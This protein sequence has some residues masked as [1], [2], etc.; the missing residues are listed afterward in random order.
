MFRALL[1]T[2]FILP[3]M[4]IGVGAK[5]QSGL[6]RLARTDRELYYSNFNILESLWVVRRL[7]KESAFDQIR[8]KEG[9]TSIL[10]GGA[11]RRVDEGAS[12][13]AQALAL[14]QMGHDDML[15]NVLYADSLISRMKFLTVD[16]QLRKFIRER[17]LEDTTV[18]PDELE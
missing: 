18:F 14:G 10:E 2:S 12:V 4:G 1:D 3:S 9:L 13:F 17:K 5:V 15:D 11:Y 6:E 8:Y 16:S 7:R